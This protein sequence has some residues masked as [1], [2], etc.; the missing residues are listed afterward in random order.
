MA[1]RTDTRIDA[2]R[3]IDRLWPLGRTPDIYEDIFPGACASEGFERSSRIMSS[4][5]QDPT[6]AEER[7][8]RLTACGDEPVVLLA[9]AALA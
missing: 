1:R 6:I 8:T 5:S 7:E 9:E 4:T 3:Q 2:D